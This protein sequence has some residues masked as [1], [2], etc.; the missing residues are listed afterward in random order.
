LEE[1][2]KVVVVISP[3][4]PVEVK[5]LDD[6]TAASRSA[7]T[8]WTHSKTTAKVGDLIRRAADPKALAQL[9]TME[10]YIKYTIDNLQVVLE[11][12]K[13]CDVTLLE[14][15][16]AQIA[17]Q[18]KATANEKPEATEPKAAKTPKAKQPK[19]PK[20]PKA[21]KAKADKTKATQESLDLIAAIMQPAASATTTATT[22]TVQAEEGQALNVSSDSVGT[23]SSGTDEQQIL[24]AAPELPSTQEVQAAVLFDL[25]EAAAE[26]EP[27]TLPMDYNNGVQTNIVDADALNV[28]APDIQLVSSPV[29]SFVDDT[30]MVDESLV[31]QTT[32]QEEVAP[33][34]PSQ[35]AAHAVGKRRRNELSVAPSPRRAA[36]RPRR[37]PLDL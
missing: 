2:L 34:V 7:K 11:A 36:P 27:E 28:N 14:S 23:A 13:A 1:Q 8:G 19:E 9:V 30:A 26:A 31:A 12:L 21:P 32:S 3:T 35:E 16:P 17:A 29:S 18:N 6:A 25:A 22:S 15:L 33:A 4:K 5:H 24:E 10:T 37:T 20:A